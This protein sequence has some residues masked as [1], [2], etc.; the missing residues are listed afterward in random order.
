MVTRETIKETRI[1][2]LK[3]KI[4]LDEEYMIRFYQKFKED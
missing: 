4:G 1:G 2:A 3:L